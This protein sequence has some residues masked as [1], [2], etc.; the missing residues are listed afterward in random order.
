MDIWAAAVADFLNTWPALDSL[1]SK[2][3][4]NPKQMLLEGA[5]IGCG[6]VLIREP[7]VMWSW[8]PGPTC[9]WEPCTKRGRELFCDNASVCLALNSRF[10]NHRHAGIV[11]VFSVDSKLGERRD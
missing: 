10:C 6:V 4:K 8:C 3:I 2:C 11:P 9:L 5:A 1:M 7:V